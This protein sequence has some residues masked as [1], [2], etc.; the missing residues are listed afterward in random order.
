MYYMVCS[1]NNATIIFTTMRV[2]KSEV[3]MLLDPRGIC[4]VAFLLIALQISI[5]NFSVLLQMK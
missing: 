4:K 2:M 3:K 5:H 1:T